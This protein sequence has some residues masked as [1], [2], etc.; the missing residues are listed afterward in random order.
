MQ[1]ILPPETDT[2]VRNCREFLGVARGW[3]QK[4]PTIWIENVGYCGRHALERQAFTNRT[5]RRGG[6]A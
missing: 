2:Q 1:S 4:E 3:C 5:M 6:A